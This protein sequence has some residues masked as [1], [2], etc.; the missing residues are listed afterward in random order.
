MASD[1]G[2]GA[3]SNQT[4]TAVVPAQQQ[5]AV[6]F[7]LY[8]DSTADADILEFTTGSLNQYLGIRSN[9]FAIWTNGNWNGSVV[10][11]TAG[12]WHHIRFIQT[13]VSIDFYLDDSL[14]LSLGGNLAG[15]TDLIFG[16]EDAFNGR[17]ANVQ[18]WDSTHYPDG[19]EA[20]RYLPDV[21]DG[22]LGWWP[23]TVGDSAADRLRDYSGNGY[24]F[25]AGGTVSDGD[26]P[27]ISW[28]AAVLA[29]P[30]PPPAGASYT[31]T[32]AAGSYALTG[33]Q[34]SLRMR[35]LLPGEAGSY[36][37]SGNAVGLSASRRL[38]AEG[39]AY[40]L[41]GQDADLAVRRRMALDAGMYALTGHDA[42]LVYDPLAATYTLACVAGSYSLIGYD[43]AL[44]TSRRLA[45][46]AES[47]TFA[48][49]PISLILSSSTAIAV[50]I[51][52]TLLVIFENRTYIVDAEDR[53]YLVE[54][55]S[56]T[57]IATGGI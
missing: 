2:G 22:L 37:L 45:L 19:N 28:G 35:R 1:F 23:M 10:A 38:A 18:L 9:Q 7:W 11:A 44:I 17:I 47:Y 13:G 25:V 20:N 27:P 26:G 42:D 46:D 57:Y 53:I 56:R 21:T 33:Q 32:C 43:A 54:A 39:G 8:L 36:V 16:G 4:L 3:G 40:A 50:P 5:F 52:R 41:S 14:E 49:V 12:E 6:S 31:L 29:L 15:K 48:G 55:E 51:W 34:A 24:D 30:T